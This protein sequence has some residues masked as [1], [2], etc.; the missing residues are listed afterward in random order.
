M[1]IYVGNN[2]CWY[3]GHT[4]EYIVADVILVWIMYG[5]ICVIYSV[6]IE[7]DTMAPYY[8]IRLKN[9]PAPTVTRDTLHHEEE[10][11]FSYIPITTEQVQEPSQFI[12]NDTLQNLLNSK[13]VTPY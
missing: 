1:N 4:V 7:M 11:D 5:Q 9:G 12:N 8:T 3:V 2:I 10:H 13:L 6:Y